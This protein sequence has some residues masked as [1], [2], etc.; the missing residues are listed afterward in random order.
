MSG[1]LPYTTIHEALR[2]RHCSGRRYGAGGGALIGS[3]Q[4][5]ASEPPADSVLAEGSALGY[6]AADLPSYRGMNSSFTNI[7]YDVGVVFCAERGSKARM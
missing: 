4:V 2:R 3:E 5:G 6:A 1:L 7:S